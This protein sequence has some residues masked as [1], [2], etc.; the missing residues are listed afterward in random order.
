MLVQLPGLLIRI[1]LWL[2]AGVQA[3][4]TALMFSIFIL[5]PLIHA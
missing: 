4:L 5:Y 2:L 3:V 1:L